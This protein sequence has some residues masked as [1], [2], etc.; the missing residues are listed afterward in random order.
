M[1]EFRPGLKRILD[2]TPVPVI[3]IGLSG[4]W[5]SIFSRAKGRLAGRLLRELRRRIGLVVGPARAPADLDLPAL[6]ATVKTLRGE[7][8]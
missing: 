6:A 2:E 4:L 8:R 3:P 7:R 1:N 5:D